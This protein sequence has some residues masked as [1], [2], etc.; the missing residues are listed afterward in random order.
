MI[1]GSAGGIGRPPARVEGPC[2]AAESASSAP[3]RQDSARVALRPPSRRVEPVRGTRVGTR[4]RTERRLEIDPPRRRGGAWQAWSVLLAAWTQRVPGVGTERLRDAWG[5]AGVSG[6]RLVAWRG[7]AAPLRALVPRCTDKI[8]A[9][10]A[11]RPPSRRVEP[12]QGTR[13]GT[14]PRAERRLGIDPPPAPCEA[15]A[16]GRQQVASVAPKPARRL[17]ALQFAKI[18]RA[19]RLQLV[20][21]R[22][23]LER[24][25]QVVEPLLILPLEVAQG[26]YRILPALR[27]RAPVVRPAVLRSRL[28]RLA[29][30][31]IAPLAFGVSQRHDHCTPLRN[32]PDP[33]PATLHPR[34]TRSPRRQSGA[35][36]VAVSGSWRHPR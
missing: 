10:V 36:A 28:L 17:H 6:D 4:P 26:A 19:N 18:K 9:R 11:L 20:G 3:H 1:R 12:V 30:R 27:S 33:A 22:G 31:S 15:V 23:L 24:I 13:V 8:S 21:K 16:T 5:S 14:R 2:R 29:P 25:G 7:L 35:L 32:G 34:C